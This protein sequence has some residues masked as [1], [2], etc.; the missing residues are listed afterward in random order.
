MD[1]SALFLSLLRT[2]SSIDLLFLLAFLFV[3]VVVV[4]AF[5]FGR[6]G[7]GGEERGISRSNE[8]LNRSN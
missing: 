7:G 4:F 3:V 5:C 1:G 2:A 8:K 6:G